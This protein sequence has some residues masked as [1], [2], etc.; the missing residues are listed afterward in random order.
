MLGAAELKQLETPSSLLERIAF[1]RSFPG[2]WSKNF[3]LLDVEGSA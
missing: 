3:E 2:F 1:A